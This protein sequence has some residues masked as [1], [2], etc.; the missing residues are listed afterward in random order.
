[1]G[2]RLAV[3]FLAGLVFAT[4]FPV[5][6]TAAIYKWVAENGTVTYR[7]TPPPAGTQVKVV[8]PRDPAIEVRKP[9]V[10]MDGVMETVQKKAGDVAQMVGD[11]LSGETSEVPR[12]ENGSSPAVELYVTSWC[13][14]CKRARAF[15]QAR[16]I[17]FQEYDIERDSAAA[18]RMAIFNPRGGVPVAVIG[19]QTLI[20][21]HQPSYERALGL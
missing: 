6:G 4:A 12:A 20:G 8:E 5:S 3:M 11:A 9:I 13:G 7:D 10:S 21:F 18:Q 2:M 17:S 15:L 1:M 19:G 16:G 14:Y